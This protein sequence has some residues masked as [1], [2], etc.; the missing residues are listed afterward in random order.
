MSAN[1]RAEVGSA[2]LYTGAS[3]T[4]GRFE[5]RIRF[6]GGQGV[7]GSFF[8][9]K[10]GSE[11]SGT[12][13]NE[14]DFEKVGADCHLESNAFFGNPATVHVQTHPVAFDICADYHTYTYE[15][16]PEY[17]AWFVDGAEI[18]RDT[19]ATAQAYA[20]NAPGGM[21]VRF[22]IWPGDSM[23]GGIL[24]PQILPVRQYVDWIQYSSYANGAFTV[25]WRDEFDQASLAAIW[26]TGSWPSPKNMSTHVP[27]NVALVDGA[28]V[29][30]LTPDTTTQTGGSGAGGAAGTA[31]MANSAGVGGGVFLP[32]PGGDAG[33]CALRAP[34]AGSK[35]YELLGFVLIVGS[36]VRRRGRTQSAGS[37]PPAGI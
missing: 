1:A 16:T 30:S 17:I 15:W 3:Y 21:Q 8:L 23:F 25:A 19:G 10:D 7:V 29:L 12:F 9:W 34:L 11:K 24:D 31:G 2:E 26:S 22:N 13:W 28:A 35:A 37:P 32:P 27:A 20:E 6:A 33:G 18:R 4:Y 14:L 36:L 5:A